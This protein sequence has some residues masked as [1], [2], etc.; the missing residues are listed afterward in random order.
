MPYTYTVCKHTLTAVLCCVD[1]LFSVQ[2]LTSVVVHPEID[3]SSIK[4][5]AA[6]G[7]RRG[8]SGGGSSRAA[9]GGGRKRKSGAAAADAIDLG[10]EDDCEGAFAVCCSLHQ[11]NGV[12]SPR[13]GG[14]GVQLPQ[15]QR[16]VTC[17]HF[18]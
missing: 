11:R 7:G 6:G 5:S 13:V 2:A 9:A 17:K 16:I 10:S 18:L 8:S 14:Q 12:S 3:P 4:G 15:Q 1:D